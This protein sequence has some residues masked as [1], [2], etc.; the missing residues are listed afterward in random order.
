LETFLI[1]NR[2]GSFQVNA[3]D[4]NQCKDTGHKDFNYEVRV[5]CEPELDDLGFVIDHHELDV[6][7]KIQA[8]QPVMGSC[9]QFIVRVAQAIRDVLQEKGVVFTGIYLAI[10]PVDAVA[11]MELT[12][13]EI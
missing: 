5:R 11:F 7:I 10:K 12:L 8:F 6:A 4:H 9:E 3:S 13:G 1:I 2:F